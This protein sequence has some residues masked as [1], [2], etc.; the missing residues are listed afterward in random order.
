M[1]TLHKSLGLPSPWDCIVLE[2]E[3]AEFLSGYLVPACPV[4]DNVAICG[5]TD[6]ASAEKI[7]YS[8]KR[9]FSQHL[10]PCRASRPARHPEDRLRL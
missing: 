7:R 2:F 5:L 3:R 1:R 8:E 6:A 10:S 9:P 4:A